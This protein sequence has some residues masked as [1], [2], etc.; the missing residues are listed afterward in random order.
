LAKAL[1]I[2]ASCGC[3]QDEKSESDN[4]AIMLCILMYFILYL[5]DYLIIKLLYSKSLLQY[6]H[7]YLHIATIAHFGNGALPVAVTVRYPLR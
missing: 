2:D 5:F 7:S 1:S 6:G 4:A 3:R